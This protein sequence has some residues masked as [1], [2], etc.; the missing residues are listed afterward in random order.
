MFILPPET[1]GSTPRPLARLY[2]LYNRAQ[3]KLWGIAGGWLVHVL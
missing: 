3:S 2:G 1:P